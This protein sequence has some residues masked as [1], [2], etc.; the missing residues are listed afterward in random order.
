MIGGYQDQAIDFLESALRDHN[1]KSMVRSQ[2]GDCHFLLAEELEGGRVFLAFRG[3]ED[4][5]DLTEDLKIYQVISSIV[6]TEI[7]IEREKRPK[8]QF[9][10]EVI[11]ITF[12]SPL[13]GDDT[14]RRFLE[15]KNFSA[16]MFHFVVELDPVSQ[17]P[18]LCSK[19]LCSEKTRLPQTENIH[20]T[21]PRYQLKIHIILYFQD[22]YVNFLS[23]VDPFLGPVLDLASYVSPGIIK[24]VYGCKILHLIRKGKYS[25]YVHKWTQASMGWDG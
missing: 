12:G 9:P 10:G 13:F 22:Q 19:H 20:H 24:M 7:L 5:K 2:N 4:K 17:P 18:L 1:L 11:N 25:K 16:K 8:E 6:T 23:T 14:A 21:I 15:E 3:T